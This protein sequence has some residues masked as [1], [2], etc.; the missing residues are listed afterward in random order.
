MMSQGVTKAVSCYRNML[1]E[2]KNAGTCTKKEKVG[3]EVH[4]K[5][6]TKI[7]LVSESVGTPEGS[8]WAP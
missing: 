6:P 1:K 2:K 4:L 5:H 3:L 7:L 8:L